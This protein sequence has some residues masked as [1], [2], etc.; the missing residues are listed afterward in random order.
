M[1]SM[2]SLQQCRI[3]K[4]VLNAKK[5]GL[6]SIDAETMA[7]V[8][9]YTQMRELQRIKKEGGSYEDFKDSLAN[10][11]ILSSASSGSSGYKKFV[12]AKGS[13][14]KRLQAVVAYKR[15]SSAAESL[16][17]S[18]MSASEEEE[19]MD[20]MEGEDHDAELEDDEEAEYEQLVMKAIEAN[21]LNE[22]KRNFMLD[23]AE[24]REEAQE[25]IDGDGSD[26]NTTPLQS[27]NTP[28][29]DPNPGMIKREPDS[30]SSNSTSDLYTPAR[31]SWGVFERP[32]DISKAYGGG[33]AISKAEMD[34]QDEEMEA[35]EKSRDA[36]D[37]AW[38]SST[39]RRE[40]EHEKEIRSALEAARGF[41]SMGNR[42]SA[43][44]SLEGVSE[45]CSWQTDLG[46][47]VLLELGM[48]LETV[49]RTDDA[50]KVY[51]KLASV[52]WS[53]SIRRNAMQLIQGLDITKQIRKD[54]TPRKAAMDMQNL[55]VVQA[56]IEKGLLIDNDVYKRDRRD[57]VSA[58]FD[59]EKSD[60]G[61]VTSLRDAYTV[62]LQVS[63]PLRTLK[64]SSALLA[65]AVRRFYFTNDQ[66]KM[67]YLKAR[68]ALSSVFIVGEAPKVLNRV[69][70]SGPPKEGT[71]FASIAD[72]S[73]A[74]S[75]ASTDDQLGLVSSSIGSSAVGE[76][77]SL[78][79]MMSDEPAP[80]PSFRGSRLSP[81][82]FKTPG[83]IYSRA[84]N[85]SWDL[86]VSLIDS[87]PYA[88][89]RV[90]PGEIRRVYLMK[91]GAVLETVPTFWGLGTSTIRSP[92]SWNALRN[93]LVFPAGNEF[94][95]STA[96]WQARKS[97]RSERILQIVLCDEQFL[98]V[99]ESSPR[100]TGPDL[101]SLWKRKVT[102][103]NRF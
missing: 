95:R 85:G 20:L 65:Q 55:Y 102:Q 35:R 58:W 12:G 54:V 75:S 36:A 47:E 60:V 82:L 14:E 2:P 77:R 91:D 32:R 15:S 1:Y 92:V 81:S 53:M 86:V 89:K 44:T 31:S 97:D 87:P 40:M 19:L 101:F 23:K 13:L 66:E 38:R 67:E 27:S 18:G 46:G 28:G 22:L 73:D 39:Q 79:A 48:A 33:R 51:G 99:R 7:K 62:F 70:S 100:A 69:G 10:G 90:E 21:K 57:S 43:V 3:S 30:S 9:R 29:Y 16:L 37:T 49:D 98:L 83:D 52:S 41:M 42:R 94:S 68:G 5:K 63:N 26:A 25:R 71:F 84:V 103:W 93:E 74:I 88:C 80:L 76:K 4:L 6:T 78:L 50:R 96:P 45:L 17:E 72:S 34:K 8:R 56:A 11:T 64:V 24:K 59:E 61:S